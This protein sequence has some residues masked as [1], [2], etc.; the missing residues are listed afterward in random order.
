MRVM[1]VE[2]EMV[3]A[4]ASGFSSKVEPAGLLVDL[5]GGVRKKDDQE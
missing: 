3:G 2:M 1:V 4:W 5:M